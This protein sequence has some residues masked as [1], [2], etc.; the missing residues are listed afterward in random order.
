MSDPASSAPRPQ[1]ADCDGRPRSR[2]G[3]AARLDVFG[4]A[5]AAHHPPMRRSVR[6]TD[7]AVP[8]APGVEASQS[9][10]CSRRPGA[11]HGGHGGRGP[12]PRSHSCSCRRP[13]TAAARAPASGRRVLGAGEAGGEGVGRTRRRRDGSSERKQGTRPVQDHGD[14]AQHPRRVLA[15]RAGHGRVAEG[16]DVHAVTVGAEGSPRP[17]SGPGTLPRTSSSGAPAAQ[18]I[19][20]IAQHHPGDCHGKASRDE[21]VEVPGPTSSR[22]GPGQAGP[23]PPPRCRRRASTWSSS[24]TCVTTRAWKPSGRSPREADDHRRLRSRGRRAAGRAAAHGHRRASRG[25]RRPRAPRPRV[26]TVRAGAGPPRSRRAPRRAPRAVAPT[27]PGSM[28]R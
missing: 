25:H 12:S 23:S 8:D 1:S 21:S 26:C 18:R 7:G 19:S 17:Q 11:A 4:A 20:M 2:C 5:H 3:V 14:L 10:R 16:R 28:R 13:T 6:R 9:T 27:R 24:P 22:Y 15:V